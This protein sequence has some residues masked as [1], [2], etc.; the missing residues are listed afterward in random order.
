MTMLLDRAM[1]GGYAVAYFEAWDACSLEAV[2]EAAEEERAP[3][4]LGFGGMMADTGWLEHIGI[5]VLAGIGQAIAARARVPVALLL[6]EAQTPAQA[7]RGIEAGFDAVML[8]TSGMP[9]AQAQAAVADLAAF[10]H[11]RGAAVEAELGHLPDAGPGGSL[12]KGDLTDPEEAATFVERTGVDCLAVSIGNVHLLTEGEAVVDLARLEAIRRRVRV[13]L[14]IHGGSSFPASAV[15]GA[16]AAGVA[17]FNVGS[18]FKRL[19]LTAVREYLGGLP[20]TAD[21][22]D[23]VGSHRTS[24][25]MAVGKAAVKPKMRELIRLYGASGRAW[26]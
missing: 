9:A 4:I 23:I 2:L 25:F 10:A 26:D 16:I 7:R 8:D 22:H 21:V 6:N 19:F 13:P 5:E 24:D 18:I 3:V 11:A 20:P 1:R 15:P 12:S 14:A 17:K